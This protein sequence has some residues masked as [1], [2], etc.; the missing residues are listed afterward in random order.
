[1]RNLTRKILISV[2][3]TIIFSILTPAVQASISRLYVGELDS[4]F[5]AGV[6][7]KAEFDG[8][9]IGGDI[10]TIIRKSVINE[11]DRTVGFLPDRTDYKVMMGLD[12]GDGWSVELAHVCY[13]RVIS[14]NDLS[15]Y[16]DA[17][18]NEIENTDVITV[19]WTF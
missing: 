19:T 8:F 9:V 17:N 13:H 11:E 16:A 1:M 15:L 2:L 3:I 5:M 10:R 14:S 18:F 7:T 6:D 4:Q 12:F